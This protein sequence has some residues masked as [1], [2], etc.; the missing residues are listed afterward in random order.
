MS[1]GVPESLSKKLN[2]KIKYSFLNNNQF[3]YTLK[4]SRYVVSAP[5]LTTILESIYLEK[6]ILFTF[7]QHGSHEYNIK[8]IKS[9]DFSENCFSIRSIFNQNNSKINSLLDIYQLMLNDNDEFYNYYKEFT[10]KLLNVIP[11]KK[12]IVLHNIYS[13]SKKLTEIK[14]II[15]YD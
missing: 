5:G 6:S 11:I 9:S 13:D 2:T 10:H 7:E 3:L 15:E 12:D 4:H 14:S 8:S 1:S